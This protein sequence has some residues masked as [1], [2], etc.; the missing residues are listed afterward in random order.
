PSW[1]TVSPVGAN[2]CACLC[3]C[4][5]YNETCEEQLP[6]QTD[7]MMCCTKN[8]VPLIS[9]VKCGTLTPESGFF[10]LMCVAG[11]FMV[12]L[13]GLLRYAHWIEKHENCKFNR[14]GLFTGRICAIGFIMV[15]SFE[16]IT[17]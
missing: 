6:Y 3:V 8:N 14:A 13:I 7:P 4:R 15:G 1:W 5:L 9:F 2:I 17:I 16:V 11:S 10:C 12:M